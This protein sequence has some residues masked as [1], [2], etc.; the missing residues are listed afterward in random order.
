MFY[1]S[2]LKLQD[3]IEDPNTALVKNQTPASKLLKQ[4]GAI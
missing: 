4:Q 2:R 3:N 1:I